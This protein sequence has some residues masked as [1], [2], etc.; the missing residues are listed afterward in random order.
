MK[1]LNVQTVNDALTDLSVEM[2]SLKN[3]TSAQLIKT[4]IQLLVKLKVI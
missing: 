1:L 2:L 3:M 4:K